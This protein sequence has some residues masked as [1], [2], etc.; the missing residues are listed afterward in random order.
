M[1]HKSGK[2]NYSPA[3]KKQISQ[4]KGGGMKKGGSPKHVC[5]KGGKKK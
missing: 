2:A 3:E 5:P 4:E 1:P